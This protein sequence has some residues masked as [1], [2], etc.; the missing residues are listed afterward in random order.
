MG[1]SKKKLN[2]ILAYLNRG[3]VVVDSSGYRKGQA[4]KLIA[5]GYD[6]VEVYPA[7]FKKDKGKRKR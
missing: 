5:A 3:Y 6:V 2:E 7:E 1:K 4:D